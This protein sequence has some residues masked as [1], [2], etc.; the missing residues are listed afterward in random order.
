M[1]NLLYISIV[2]NLSEAEKLELEKVAS[3][4]RL[5]LREKILLIPKISFLIVLFIPVKSLAKVDSEF[6]THS[7]LGVSLV[8][9]Q[10]KGG[11]FFDD[12]SR[13]LLIT[14]LIQLDYPVGMTEVGEY[15]A[16]GYKNF[17]KGKY[18][19]LNGRRFSTVHWKNYSF[20]K[21]KRLSA[22]LMEDGSEYFTNTSIDQTRAAI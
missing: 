7:Q 4:N 19:K 18:P 10:I 6:N 9:N 1:S 2:S 22:R 15:L 13:N 21:F 12:F 16:P 8:Q 20:S 3:R 14:V 5:V 17:S 11:G